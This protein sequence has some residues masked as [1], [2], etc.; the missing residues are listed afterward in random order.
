[1]TRS[2]LDWFS[3]LVVYKSQID[4]GRKTTRF[5]WHPNYRSCCVAVRWRWRAA[6]VEACL[7]CFR[8]ERAFEEHV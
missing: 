7:V 6:R 5:C 2:I 4:S 3:E 8:S 1:M